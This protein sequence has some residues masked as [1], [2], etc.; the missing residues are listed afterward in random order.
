MYMSIPG[1]E[2]AGAYRRMELSVWRLKG[3]AGTWDRQLREHLA[4]DP[5][6]ALLGGLTYGEWQP[7]HAFCEQPRLPCLF[8]L[9]DL[10]VISEADWYP[11]Y[12]SKGYH[13]EGQA[14]ARYL[15]AQDPVPAR[16]LQIVQAGPEGLALARG[17][18]E[19]WQEAGSGA[20][21]ELQLKPGEVLSADSLQGILAQEQPAV[22][23]LWTGSESFAA[24]EG[25][26]GRP[27]R[28]GRSSCPGGCWG[29]RCSSSLK[30]PGPSPG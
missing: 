1:K 26:A 23:L 16:V 9:T 30:R 25:L 11:Q 12:L 24:L 2:M 22:L 13:Q 14:A 6:F 29:R 17:F 3:P 20:V 4:R 7:I 15:Q 18:R 10:P 21:K 5:V 28:R 27:G 8:P 19:T